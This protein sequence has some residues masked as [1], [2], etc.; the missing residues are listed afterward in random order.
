MGVWIAQVVLGTASV[1][2]LYFLTKDF[3]GAG[4]ACVA[5][6]F[7]STDYLLSKQCVYALPETLGIFF[8]IL[9][10]YF[11]KKS[12]DTLRFKFFVLLGLSTALCALT[13]ESFSYYFFML[14]VVEGLR[15]LRSKK[16]LRGVIAFF[17]TFILLISVWVV[18]NKIHD[19]RV[20]LTD[21]SGL[22]LYLGNNP[23]VRPGLYGGEWRLGVDTGYPEDPLPGIGEDAV[24]AD[25]YY[26]QKALAY[27]FSNPRQTFLNGLIKGVRLWYPFYSDSSLGIKVL[28][29][30][31]YVLIMLGA[32][33]GIYQSRGQWPDFLWFYLLILYLTGIHA[34]TVSAIRYRYPLMPFLMMMAGYGFHEIWLKVDP[35]KIRMKSIH[36][37]L[38]GSQ[39]A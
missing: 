36:S 2:L 8:L 35:E 32:L 33:A 4:A 24:F 39:D 10:I 29:G 34:L 1:L 23:T 6:S 22:T 28:T 37:S 30:V 19:K 12:T 14:A 27:I 20:F 38:K 9:S 11:L 15:H 7:F 16:G 25:A 5:A 3:F 21:T 17:V 26:R 31:P 18:R 13:K